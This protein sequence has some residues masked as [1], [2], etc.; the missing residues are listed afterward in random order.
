MTVKEL[1]EVFEE[2]HKVF[3]LPTS[4]EFKGTHHII[5]S[6]ETNKLE[7][8]IWVE[9]DN[10]IIRRIPFRFEE[11]DMEFIMDRNYLQLLKFKLDDYLKESNG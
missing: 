2:I 9:M 4:E 5:L 6:R 1:L 8:C 3:P 10:E 11:E 7:L